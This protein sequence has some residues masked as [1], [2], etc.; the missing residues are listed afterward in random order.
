MRTLRPILFVM[1]L[2]VSGCT[3]VGLGGGSG[4]GPTLT[5][6]N[7][8]PLP[9]P[10]RT[11]V[12]AHLDSEAGAAAFAAQREALN[13]PSGGVAVPWQAGTASGTVTPGPIHT[14]NQRSC[15]DVVHVSERDMER[16]KGRS[17]LCLTRSGEWKALDAI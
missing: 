14:V 7:N 8:R 4:D 13:A 1:A 12:F 15:R 3:S 2:I 10:P 16:V 5:A 11:G 6:A 9:E 17:T